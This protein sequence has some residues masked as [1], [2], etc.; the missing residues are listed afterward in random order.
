MKKWIPTLLLGLSLLAGCTPQAK[1]PEFV[2]HLTRVEPATGHI[3]WSVAL[4]ARQGSRQ[5]DVQRGY[6]FV[7]DDVEAAWYRLADG[8]RVGACPT[9]KHHVQ[10]LLDG[11]QIL[12]PCQDGLKVL[13]AS[14]GTEKFNVP[15]DFS[16]DRVARSG[17]QVWV[18]GPHLA[19]VDLQERRAR[20]V[21]LTGVVRALLPV[22]DGVCVGNDRSQLM[23]IQ[24]DGQVQWQ[25]KMEYPAGDMLL[26]GN[27]LLV[28]SGPQ[29]YAFDAAT[30]RQL[31]RTVLKSE[32]FGLTLDGDLVLTEADKTTALNVTDG[33]VRWDAPYAHGDALVNGHVVRLMHSR[34]D[35][36]WFF[37]T[38]DAATG[39]VLKTKWSWHPT[40]QG[41]QTDGQALYLLDA[42]SL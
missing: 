23:A 34:W 35:S 19:V 1:D 42:Y 41:L 28:T 22:R 32:A 7:S 33:R 25:T 14:N 4:P 12:M 6:A 9:G 17:K 3:V 39:D 38:R 37:E 8:R 13:D 5:L 15:V 30:G 31:W 40:L 27:R 26:S 10:P 18:A 16:P 24:A 11:D 36:P 2:L 20:R 21:E 29:V